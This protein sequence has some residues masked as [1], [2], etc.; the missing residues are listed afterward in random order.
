MLLYA[1]YQ[2]YVKH[3]DDLSKAIKKYRVSKD[4]Q[5]GSVVI[6]WSSIPSIVDSKIVSTCTHL[7]MRSQKYD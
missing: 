1:V 3:L 6:G 2:G 4:H 5:C 7:L